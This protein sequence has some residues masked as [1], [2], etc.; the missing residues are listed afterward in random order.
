MWS[1]PAEQF[2]IFF[3]RLC[4]LEALKTG[5]G[6]N[7]GGNLPSR[8]NRRPRQCESLRSVDGDTD[9]TMGHAENWTSSLTLAWEPG[10]SE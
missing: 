9:V 3:G 5:S 7:Q 2:D 4:N 6:V 10:E 1:Q 8:P